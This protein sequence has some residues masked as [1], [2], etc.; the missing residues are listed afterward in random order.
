MAGY[1]LSPAAEADFADIYRY[2]ILTFGEKRADLY[3][4]DLI[5]AFDMLGHN[6]LAGEDVATIRP[7]TRRLVHESHAIYYDLIDDCV[8]RVL[9]ILHQTQDPMRHL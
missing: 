1:K 4:S 9:R 2:S 3:A 6:Q 8:V 7:D 5:D